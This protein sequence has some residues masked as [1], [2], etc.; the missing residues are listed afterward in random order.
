MLLTRTLSLTLLVAAGFALLP[1]GPV[2]TARQPAKD[3]FP[4]KSPNYNDVSTFKAAPG[5][6]PAEMKRAKDAFAG[7]AQYNA[8]YI[9]LPRLYTAPQEFAPV[10]SKTGEPIATTDSLIGELYRHILVPVPGSQ[11]KP[12]NADYIRELGAALDGALKDVI[13]N[14]GERVVRVNAARMLA[15]A[16]RSGAAAHYPTVTALVSNANTPPEV[17]YYAFQAAANL[18]AAYDINDYRTR[19]HSGKANEVGDLIAALQDAI[20]RPNAI[21]AAPAPLPPDQLQVVGFI[22]RQAVRALA[23]VRY[24]D[25][26]PGGASLYPA[27]TLA[28]VAVSDPAIVPAPGPSEIADA[29]MGICNMSPP[30]APPG[31]AEPY[32]YAMADA[33][34]TGVVAF[35]TPRSRN[36]DDKS[37][38]WR[39][40]AAK[41]SEALKAWRGPFDPGFNP[42]A[43]TAFVPA[44][45]PAVVNVVVAEAERQV[46]TPMDGTAGKINVDGLTKYRDGVLRADKKWTLAPFRDNPKL[47]LPNSK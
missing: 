34:A 11:V 39:G 40:T 6:T 44:A 4:K 29:V 22:R 1:N 32:A 18:L 42:A 24:S 43:P 3:E 13:N 37:V 35:A 17:K 41:L 16:C 38:A 9:A 30:T 26:V 20:V 33:V 14:N 45:V 46:L 10:T 27:F 19:A 36:R 7:F 47:V 23:Q 31:A 21:L 8:E 15:T 25:K 5:I 28:R 2:A 12:A